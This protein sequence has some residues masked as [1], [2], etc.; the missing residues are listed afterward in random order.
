MPPVQTSGCGGIHATA[1]CNSAAGERWRPRHGGF[2]FASPGLRWVKPARRDPVEREDR[3]GRRAIRDCAGGGRAR[4]ASG[5]RRYK[6]GDQSSWR[7]FDP[8]HRLARSDRPAR[9]D[10]QPHA[11]APVRHHLEVRGPLGR[12]G[13]AQGG[14]RAASGP[15]RTRQAGRMDLQPGRLGSRAVRR[16]FEA[17]HS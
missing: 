11:P 5:C 10:R 7:P 15:D 8:S 16:R 4:R 17:V 1:S 6:P 9:T 13:I 2:C 14:A 3:H 12:C